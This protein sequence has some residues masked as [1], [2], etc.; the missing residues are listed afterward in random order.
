MSEAYQWCMYVHEDN[1][2]HRKYRYIY[3][4]KQTE[5]DPKIYNYGF[6]VE[7]VERLK[8]N[9]GAQFLKKFLQQ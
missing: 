1:I 9:T 5:V 7:V 6:S 4:Y 3:T 8:A 2:A